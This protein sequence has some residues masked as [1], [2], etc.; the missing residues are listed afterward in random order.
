MFRRSDAAAP[1]R[2]DEPPPGGARFI[3]RKIAFRDDI[4]A[5]LSVSGWPL[6]LLNAAAGLPLS[7]KARTCLDEE[8]GRHDATR[9]AP[10][11][12]PKR[13][14]AEEGQQLSPSIKNTTLISAHAQAYVQYS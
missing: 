14:A 6:F 10:S 4:G 9:A 8:Q 1:E 13:Y 2:Q 3:E 11:F 7:G 12:S 5:I